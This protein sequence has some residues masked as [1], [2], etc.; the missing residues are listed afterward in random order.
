[1]LASFTGLQSSKQGWHGAIDRTADLC[2]IPFRVSARPLCS[3]LLY[4]LNA[5]LHGDPPDAA[6]SKPHVK[7]AGMLESHLIGIDSGIEEFIDRKNLWD[8]RT[9]GIT[10]RPFGAALREKVSKPVKIELI[11]DLML[12]VT[13]MR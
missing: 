3:L 12:T 6:A 4:F 8:H 5:Y 11:P 2:R 13:S 1:V 10:A 7:A 9:H